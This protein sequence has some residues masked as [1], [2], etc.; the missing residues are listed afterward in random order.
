MFIDLNC[1]LRWAMWPMGLL[2]I[3]CHVPEVKL[4]PTIYWNDYYYTIRERSSGG[5][6]GITLSVCLSICLS[7]VVVVVMVVIFS[8]FS[9]EPLDQFNQTWHN[10]S[11]G[12]GDSNEEPNPFPREEKQ[13]SK[14]ALSNL[15]PQNRW[16]RF[17][18]TW[19]KASLGEGDSSLFKWRALPFSKGR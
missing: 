4:S 14:N 13:N 18:Q 5:Y 11:L 1:F 10:A 7:V 2:F 6:I 3:Y 12:E 9:Q 17:N 19:H 8:S 15:F 16:A